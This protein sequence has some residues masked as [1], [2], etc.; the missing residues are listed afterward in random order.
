MLY[1]Q[2]GYNTYIAYK[3]SI[4]NHHRIALGK[5]VQINPFV[6]LWPLELNIGNHVQINA[7]TTIYGKVLIGNYVMIAPNCVLAGGNHIFS[8][9]EIPIMFQNSVEKGIV[10]EDDVWIG[11]NCSIV[12]GV[13][14][15][16]GAIIGANSVV[17][18]DVAPLSIV[19]GNPAKFVKWRKN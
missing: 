19:F 10:I 3:S 9:T 13:T 16:K 14:I 12:D 17:T 4:R 7:G 1:K 11:A 2:I 18:K 8:D 15:G 6:T 5:K